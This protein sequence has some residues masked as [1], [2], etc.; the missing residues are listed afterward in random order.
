MTAMPNHALTWLNSLLPARHPAK[1]TM[2]GMKLLL[3]K[4]TMFG[5]KTPVSTNPG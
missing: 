1:S 3:M 2:T 5:L 4:S